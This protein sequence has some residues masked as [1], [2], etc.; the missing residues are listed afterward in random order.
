MKLSSL[1]DYKSLLDSCN[2][3]INPLVDKDPI[4]LMGT[5]GSHLLTD[6]SSLKSLGL[7]PTSVIA[8]HA[9]SMMILK[10][11]ELASNEPEFT[12]EKVFS[13]ERLSSPEILIIIDH[14]DKWDWVVPQFFESG[15]LMGIELVVDLFSSFWIEY[16]GDGKLSDKVHKGEYLDELMPV[17]LGHMSLTDETPL[18]HIIG[19]ELLFHVMNSVLSMSDDRWELIVNCTAHDLIPT[20]L[21]SF[22]NDIK[23]DEFITKYLDFQDAGE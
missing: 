13:H 12:I 20:A 14:D 15:S 5:M 17:I 8:F 3:R 22:I 23:H 6:Y 10:S 1:D 4:H 7:F 11:Y 18:S 19:T 9:V 16:L 21:P 2:L